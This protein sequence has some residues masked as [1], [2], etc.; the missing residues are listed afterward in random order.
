VV[1]KLEATRETL[2]HD[3]GDPWLSY[4][5]GPTR[6][7]ADGVEISQVEYERLQMVELA[8]VDLLPWQQDVLLRSWRG[9]GE[10]SGAAAGRSRTGLPIHR[11]R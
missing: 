2:L 8:G 6:Y 7:Y 11:R 10:D 9:P 3:H 4:C 5:A 1:V